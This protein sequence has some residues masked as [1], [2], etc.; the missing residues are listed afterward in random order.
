MSVAEVAYQLI[1]ASVAAFLD[2]RSLLY[3][4]VLSNYPH[5]KIMNSICF[6]LCAALKVKVA[7]K[8]QRP[9]WLHSLAMILFTGYGGGIAAPMMMGACICLLDCIGFVLNTYLI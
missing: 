6:A 7:F 1:D 3:T 8:D 2:I 5:G 9:F 4:V